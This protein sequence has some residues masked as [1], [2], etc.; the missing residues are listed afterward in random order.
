M[1]V[2]GYSGWQQHFGGDP[3]VIGR[4]FDVNRV[5]F[6]IVGVSAR[7]FFGAHPGNEPDF[8]MPLTMQSDARYYHGNH[9]SQGSNPSKPWVPQEKIEWLHLIAR[10][11]D[12]SVVP[13]LMAQMN[14]QY[15]QNLEL[16]LQS[17]NDVQRQRDISRDHLTLEP[18]QQGLQRSRKSFSSRC[19][20]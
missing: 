14:Q 13:H 1:A 11:Q 2:T 20:C 7:G 5:P 15:R 3:G 17:Q 16:L 8:W 12:S 9:R 6:T 19:S 18:G 4:K 10:I